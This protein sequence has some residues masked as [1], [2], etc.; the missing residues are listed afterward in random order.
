MKTHVQMFYSKLASNL[1]TNY[2]LELMNSIAVL[3]K[4]IVLVYI[5]NFNYSAYP[6]MLLK[7]SVLLKYKQG[8]RSESNS[9]KISERSCRFAGLCTVQNYNSSMKLTVFPEE[10]KIAKL[11]PLFKAGSKTCPKNCRYVTSASSVQ[12]Y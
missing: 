7:N 5:T 11:R 6:K 1:V 4:T 2:Q 9:S 8:S 12:N 10:C 3:L